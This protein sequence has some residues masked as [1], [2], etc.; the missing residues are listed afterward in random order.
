ML[1]VDGASHFDSTTDHWGSVTF[2]AHSAVTANKYLYFGSAS[3]SAIIY[4]TD[5]TPDALT[6]AVSIASRSLLICEKSDESTDFLNPQQTNPTL[7]F[8]SADATK[9]YEGGYYTWNSITGKAI[10]AV[11]VNGSDFTVTAQAGGTSGDRDGG[12]LILWGGTKGNAGDDGWVSIGTGAPA[13]MIKATNSLYVAGGMEVLNTTHFRGA[14]AFWNNAN[15]V[16]NYKL[17]FGDGENAAIEYDGGQTPDSWLFGVPALSNAMVV[18]EKADMGVDFAH[19]QQTNPTIFIHSADAT[20]TTQWISLA[21]DQTDAVISSGKGDIYLNPT[22]LVKFGTYAAIVA[23]TL[24]GY[25]TINDNLG[26]PRKV[27]IVA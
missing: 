27:A 2:Y 17:Y 19:A 1:E 15:I 26:N 22:G 14:I 16:S 23:E 9:I 25:V 12:R 10:G 11:A 24:Q 3:D 8:Q 18:C 13:Y 4:N 5:Q 21:H 20:D 7:I 6:V